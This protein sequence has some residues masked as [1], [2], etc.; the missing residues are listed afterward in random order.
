VRMLVFLLIV[1]LQAPWGAAQ[2]VGVSD[3]FDATVRNDLVFAGSQLDATA[4][5]ISKSS[6]PSSTSSGGRWS[7]TGA[8]TWTSGFFPGALWR[9]YE[10]TG[11]TLWSTRATDWQ[12]G[13][14]GQKSDTSSHDV[15]FKIFTSFGNAYRLT[16]IDAYRQVVLQGA[17]SLASRYSPIVG[18]IRSWDGPTS[19]DFRVIID[20]MMNLEILFWASKHGGQASW[21]DMAVSHALKTMANHVRSDGSTYQGVNYNPSTGTVKAK[22]THQGEA[23]ESTWSRGQAWAVYGFTMAYRETGDSRFLETARRVADY[24]IGHLPSD[25]VPYWDF[26]ASGIPNEPRD[27]SAAAIAAS[28]LLE[29]AGLETDSVRATGYAQAAK[30]TLTSLSSS[31]YLAAGTGNSAILLHATQNEPAGASDTGLIYG[32]YYFIEALLRYRSLVGTITDAATGRAVAGATIGFDAG[33]TQSRVDGRYL[34]A[35]IG[36]GDWTITVSAPGYQTVSRSVTM[37]TVGGETLDVGMLAGAPTPTPTPTPKPT[38]TTAP[39]PT[40]PGGELTFAPVADA[41]VKSTSP[42]TNYGTLATIRLRED[43]ASMPVNYRSYL[44]F[45]VSGLSGSPASVRLRLYV[46]DASVD[47]GTVY[48]TSGTWTETGLTWS[49]RPP[50]SGGALGSAGPTVAAGSWEEIALSPASVPGNGTINLLLQSS[51]TDSVIYASREDAS[52]RPTLIV[53]TG[54]APAPTPTPTPT[55]TRT[56][57]PTPT[58]T[59][60]AGVD[61]RFTPIA[62]A[63]VKSSSPSTNYGSLTSFR[64]REDLSIA[65]ITYRSYLR[66]TVSGLADAPR[67]VRLRLYVTDASVDGGRVFPTSNSWV[68]T[69]L[70]W[71]NRPAATGSSVGGARTV[72]SGWIE[73]PLTPAAVPGNATINLLL[74]SASTDSVIYASREDASH[75]PELIIT[76]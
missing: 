64:L 59:P 68:E 49:S 57:S 72:G 54:G 13:V 36:A 21:Y 30:D 35:G 50:A 42:S 60:T 32:D 34:L 71:S 61:L 9:M 43:T 37:P 33:S 15:G 1:A 6:Y 52:H 31:A 70:T 25:H 20:N 51:S 53:S 47:G 28:G 16:G 48:P 67:A 66:F 56:P 11:G 44:R 12:T 19:S 65:P 8:S 75:R 40:P 22:F 26:E 18:S 41:Q 17:S 55:P 58:P 73:I 38:P 14:E 45:T 2:A 23:V 76:P 24:Y 10:Q 69:G 5:A 3:P 7:T 62:D 29:L 27:T 63:Q 46:T 74:Q 4:R 39:T